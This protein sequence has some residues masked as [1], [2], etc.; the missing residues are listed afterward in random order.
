MLEFSNTVLIERPLE[1]VFDFLAEL[2]NIPNWNYYVLRVQKITPGPVNVGTMYHQVRKTD[3]QT[4]VI[5]KFEPPNTL[6]VETTDDSEPQLKMRLSLQPQE[7]GTKLEDYWMLDTGQP[8]LIEKLAGNKV[9]TAVAENLNKLKVL[10]ETG[11]VVL[12]DGR[13]VSLERDRM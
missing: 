3:E 10:L 8:G 4:L 1:E 6:L 9:K 13:M 12:Q 2:E 11:E 7:T 5:R